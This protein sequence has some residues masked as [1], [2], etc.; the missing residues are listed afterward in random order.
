MSRNLL[1]ASENSH[2]VDYLAFP[3]DG[4]IIFFLLAG[5]S[6]M[7]YFRLG[8]KL[9]D[10]LSGQVEILNLGIFICKSGKRAV[11]EETDFR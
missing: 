9:P 7:T 1:I 3:Q 11:T 4:V 10:T 8:K 5:W 2:P 6:K